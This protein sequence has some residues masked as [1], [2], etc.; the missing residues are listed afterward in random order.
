MYIC[1]GI[2]ILIYK[3]IYTYVYINIHLHIHLYIHTYMYMYVCMHVCIYVYI[4]A[5]THINIYIYIWFKLQVYVCMCVCMYVLMI[6]CTYIHTQKKMLTVERHARHMFSNRIVFFMHNL[7]ARVFFFVPNNAVFF[8]CVRILHA[9]TIALPPRTRQRKKKHR[10]LLLRL[11]LLCLQDCLSNTGTQ[12]QY[13]QQRF[14]RTMS[15]YY[16]AGCD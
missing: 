11:L 7:P 3:C 9:R 2:F 12:L 1:I 10:V 16:G 15:S 4:H 13:S 8:L 6:V 14:A 5:Y